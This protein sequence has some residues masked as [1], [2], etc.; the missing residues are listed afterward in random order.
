MCFH[1]IHIDIPYII[2]IL[3]ALTQNFLIPPESNE[4]TSLSF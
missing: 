1:I 4:K 2:I 3:I